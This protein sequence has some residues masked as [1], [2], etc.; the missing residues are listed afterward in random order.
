MF[1]NEIVFKAVM[2]MG[3]GGGLSEDSKGILIT[4]LA[5]AQSYVHTDAAHN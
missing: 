4:I 3:C 5:I 2:P 1:K